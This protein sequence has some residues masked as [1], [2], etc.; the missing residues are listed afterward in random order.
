MKE[1]ANAA[2]YLEGMALESGWKVV[3]KIEKQSGQTGA[4]FSV[5]Y[6]VERD[7][8]KCFLKAFD[9][10]KFSSIAEG[11]SMVDVM[12]NM[13]NAFRF[14]RD[15]SEQCRNHH[16]TKV[17]FVTDSGEERISGYEIP[18]VPYLIFEL[19][20]GD[21]RT[22]LRF[23]NDL[24]FAWKLESLHS[25]AVGIKQLH[26]IE[27]SHQDLKPSNVLVFDN[28][29]KI[30]DLGRSISKSLHAPHDGLYFTGQ[31]S[32]APPEIMYGIY[33]KDWNIRAFAIDAYLF[34]SLI[35]FYFTGVSINALIRKF[36]PD[37][38]SWEYWRGNDFNEVKDYLLDA[39]QKAL[40]EFSESILD[41]YFSKELTQ[42]VEYLC[43]PI[44]EKRGHPRNIGPIGNNYNMERFISK[45]DRLSKK[46]KYSLIKSK[47]YG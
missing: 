43:Y 20:D 36:L 40:N 17:V 32:Y 5:L 46:A 3:K 45:L 2:H 12:A 34:G 37:S 25:V 4:F 35:V 23:S 14:E 41:E 44:P 39:F 18:V 29:S 30:G 24:D 15:L 26:Q 1:N 27:V 7:S 16:V 19:A 21:I 38:V 13:L 28:E 33:S 9:F 31:N 42:L 11:T 10:S 47:N 6:H 22:K 8:K